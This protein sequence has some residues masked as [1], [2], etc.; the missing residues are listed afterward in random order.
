[1]NKDAHQATGVC[2]RACG[3][4]SGNRFS[5]TAGQA[6]ALSISLGD[7]GRKFNSAMGNLQA[8]TGW[9]TRQKRLQQ[10]LWS[11]VWEQLQQ[12]E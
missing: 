10:G 4:S 2:S 1:M 7:A 9:L 5:S 11:Q 6:S 3:A 12:Y 8:W